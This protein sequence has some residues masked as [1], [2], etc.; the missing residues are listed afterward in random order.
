[1]RK[2]LNGARATVLAAS[3]L[4]HAALADPLL[5]QAVG[6]WGGVGEAA[7]DSGAKPEAVRCRLSNRYDGETGRLTVSG[8]CAAA[9]EIRRLNGWLEPT[10]VGDNYRGSWA[11]PSGG[12]RVSL[13]G[14]SN[15][16]V[17]RLTYK[18]KNIESGETITGLVTWRF[19]ENRL[20]LENAIAAKG[21]YRETG[22][23]TFT[24]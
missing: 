14:G 7:V 1:M 19:G 12:G 18:A 9:G 22:S 20:I 3:L 15:G 17:I 6:D 16:N 4:P 5:A 8:R 23:V 13:F 10:G 2:V 24:R 11:N 21:A